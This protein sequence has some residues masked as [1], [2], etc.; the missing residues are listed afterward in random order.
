MQELSTINAP[1]TR[2]R[3]NTTDVKTALSNGTWRHRSRQ[4]LVH[5]LI[6]VSVTRWIDVHVALG[7]QFRHKLPTKYF[8][9]VMPVKAFIYT[10]LM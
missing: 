9:V 6:T 4:W 10:P 1:N 5:V 3:L 8:N 2:R 7:W